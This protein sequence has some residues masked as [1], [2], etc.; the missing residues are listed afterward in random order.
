MTS[1]SITMYQYIHFQKLVLERLSQHKETGLIL[2]F[3]HCASLS[4]GVCSD[5]VVNSPHSVPQFT[6]PFPSPTFFPFRVVG[7]AGANL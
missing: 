1:G 6:D 2:C 3:S 7:V 4:L 5:C